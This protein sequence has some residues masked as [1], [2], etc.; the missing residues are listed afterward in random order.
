MLELFNEPSSDHTPCMQ[1]TKSEVEPQA[2]MGSQPAIVDGHL[3]LPQGLH[4]C[5]N[6]KG[7]KSMQT[8]QALWLSCD[9]QVNYK[10]SEKS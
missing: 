8:E 10:I 5:I 7:F 3:H 4:V 1:T 2:K 6:S 9:L